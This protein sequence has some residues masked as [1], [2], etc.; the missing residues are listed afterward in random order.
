MLVKRKAIK[1]PGRYSISEPNFYF[2]DKR[3]Q[4]HIE[5]RLGVNW[6]VIWFE[7]YGKRIK[8]DVIYQVD[9]EVDYKIIKPDAFLVVQARDKSLWFFFLEFD[10]AESGNDFGKKVKKYNDLFETGMKSAWWRQHTDG[11]PSIYVVTTG[12]KE[13]IKKKISENNRHGLDFQIFSLEWIITQ[14]SKKQG[15]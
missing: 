7:K 14:C 6:I 13:K 9:F 5:H 8:G 4:S 10:R 2:L 3:P 11:F 1:P 15:G 12:S